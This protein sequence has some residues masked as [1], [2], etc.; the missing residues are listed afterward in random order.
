[1]NTPE[2]CDTCKYCKYDVMH[3]DDPLSTS[4]CE[5][6]LTPTDKECSTWEHWSQK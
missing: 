6:G 2:P 3:E 1:M 4:W 5:Y